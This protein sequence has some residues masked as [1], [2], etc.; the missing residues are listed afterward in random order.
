MLIKGRVLTVF[1]SMILAFG[2]FISSCGDDDDDDGGNRNSI[3]KAKSTFA[4]NFPKLQEGAPG[5]STYVAQ[6]YED[7]MKKTGKSYRETDILSMGD[8]TIAQI[9]TMYLST[10]T[11][12]S[13]P[14]MRAVRVVSYTKTG[15]V[16]LSNEPGK[17]AEKYK[18]DLLAMYLGGDSAYR[19]EIGSIMGVEEE[20]LDIFAGGEV[21]SYNISRIQNESE[22]TQKE[23]DKLLKDYEIIRIEDNVL[24][25]DD[26]DS[27]DTIVD[28][29][30]IDDP[31]AENVEDSE[32]G[33]FIKW[34]TVLDREH[35]FYKR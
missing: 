27:S 1:M 3:E 22:L 23:K 7:T 6:C 28:A 14:I 30:D 19:N 15:T 17:T 21:Y 31:H 8:S 34:P 20:V 5:V 16:N 11:E 25:M 32:R 26:Q 35:P 18:M 9:A 10:D 33:Y 13:N 12:C 2:L 4:Q 29:S 24:Y